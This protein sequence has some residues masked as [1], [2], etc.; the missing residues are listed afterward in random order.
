M[1]CWVIILSGV[2]IRCNFS[3]QILSPLPEFIPI[4]GQGE[5][6]MLNYLGKNCDICMSEYCWIR[7]NNH[8]WA[9]V[10][11]FLRKASSWYWW[12]VKLLITWSLGRRIFYKHLT[13]LTYWISLWKNHSLCNVMK[14]VAM[15]M[16]IMSMCNIMKMDTVYDCSLVVAMALRKYFIWWNWW[17]HIGCPDCAESKI[18]SNKLGLVLWKKER[19]LLACEMSW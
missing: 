7:K 19:S 14:V 13:K 8:Y 1:H 2:F 16:Y 4:H 18:T 3:R 12:L 6:F 5:A 17:H 9:N 11:F 15:I 10:F